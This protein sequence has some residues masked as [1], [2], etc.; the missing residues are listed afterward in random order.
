MKLVDSSFI[1]LNQGPTFEDGLRIIEEVG[2][3]CYKSHDKMTSD[4]YQGFTERM[5]KSQHYAMLEFF[6]VYLRIDSHNPRYQEM[7][8]FYEL[9]PFSK[10]ER[11]LSH[12]TSWLYITTNYRVIVENGRESDLE[13]FVE[14]QDEHRKRW[15]ARLFCSRSTSHEV[16]RHRLASYAMESQRYVLYSKQKY[17]GEITFIIPDKIYRIR[18]EVAKYVDPLTGESRE[19]IKDLHGE[20]LV[21]ELICIDRGVSCWW[22]AMKRDEEDYLYLTKE[23]EWAA[24]DARDVLPNACHTILNVCMYDIDWIHFFN[25]RSIGSTGRPDPNMKRLADQVLSGFLD[26][27]MVRAEDLWGYDKV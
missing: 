15:I 20:E 16:I 12:S 6:T 21:H 23:E 9:N 8:R 27:G 14:P 17:G 7:D 18:D 10:V 4:S 5:I 11:V 26:R 24:E 1:I 25:L 2:R 22:D 13:F 19:Y 3:S